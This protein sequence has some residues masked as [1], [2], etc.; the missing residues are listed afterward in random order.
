MESCCNSYLKA[1]NIVLQT[2]AVIRYGVLG[3]K[4]CC[5]MKNILVLV[6]VRLFVDYAYAGSKVLSEL[7]YH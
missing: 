3:L 5:R 1:T 4:E 7:S 6:G 2:Y